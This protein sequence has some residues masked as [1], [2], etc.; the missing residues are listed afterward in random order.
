[1]IKK[2]IFFDDVRL[3]NDCGLQA[4]RQGLATAEDFIVFSLE[5]YFLKKYPEKK[6][7]KSIEIWLDC[8]AEKLALGDEGTI[9]DFI[10]AVCRQAIYGN[11]PV[12]AMEEVK[13]NQR[14]MNWWSK[15]GE[16]MSLPK[17]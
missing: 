2:I 4:E 12:N 17:G 7:K 1:M 14:K 13:Q 16:V 15:V 9:A 8:E 11:A 10:E 3:Y 6:Y 5:Q